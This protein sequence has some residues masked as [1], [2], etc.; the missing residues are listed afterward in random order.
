MLPRDY[1]ANPSEA[2]PDIEWTGV[3]FEQ[4]TGAVHGEHIQN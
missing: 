3:Q 1:Q 4:N 2:N